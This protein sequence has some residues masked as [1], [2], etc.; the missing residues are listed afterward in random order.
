MSKTKYVNLEDV[1]ICAND[2]CLFEEDDRNNFRSIVEAECKI[3]QVDD[4]QKR[5]DK[6]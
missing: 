3:I 1:L 5:G 2:F 6:K 4:K